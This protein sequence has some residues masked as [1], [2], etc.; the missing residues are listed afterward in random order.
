[1]KTGSLLTLALSALCLAGGCT[2]LTKKDP[3]EDHYKK[4]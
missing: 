3:A 4:S 2:S 1:M